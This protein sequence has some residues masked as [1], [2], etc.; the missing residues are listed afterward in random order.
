MI[1]D[2]QALLFRTMD[3][4][5]PAVARRLKDRI[6]PLARVFYADLLIDMH[7]RMKEA[8]VPVSDLSGAVI[9]RR[10]ALDKR[11]NYLAH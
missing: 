9:L 5:D 1:A 11:C 8:L 2:L 6:N 4:N 3:S 7:N 10:I